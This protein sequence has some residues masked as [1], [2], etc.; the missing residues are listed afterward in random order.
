MIDQE[1]NNRFGNGV[2]DVLFDHIEVRN[3]Q[4]LYHLGLG[5]FPEFGVL[6]DLDDWRHAGEFVPWEVVALCVRGIERIRL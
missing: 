2:I 6:G 4:S 1:G 3:D 5:L